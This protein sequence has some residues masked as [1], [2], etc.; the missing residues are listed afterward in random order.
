MNEATP[1]TTWIDGKPYNIV[2][3]ELVTY[4]TWKTVDRGGRKVDVRE[5]FSFT[6]ATVKPA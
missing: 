1:D 4:S 3:R 6:I 5:S 2:D